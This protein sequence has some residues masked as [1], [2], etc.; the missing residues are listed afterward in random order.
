MTNKASEHD[1]MLQY[2]MEDSEH[3]DIELYSNIKGRIQ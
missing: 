3:E 1:V 2:N